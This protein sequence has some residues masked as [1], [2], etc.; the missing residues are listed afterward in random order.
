MIRI[1]KSGIHKKGFPPI[2]LF[3]LQY[4]INTSLHFPLYLFY[5]FQRIIF[6]SSIFY[7]VYFLI[8]RLCEM[9]LL[10][11]VQRSSCTPFSVTVNCIV[12]LDPWNSHRSSIRTFYF[13]HTPGLRASFPPC[14]CRVPRFEIDE[15]IT[16][17]ILNA[18]S[19]AP[20]DQMGVVWRKSWS[21]ENRVDDRRVHGCLLFTLIRRV[22]VL[23]VVAGMS[24]SFL[25][26][27]VVLASYFCRWVRLSA[28]RVVDLYFSR[29]VKCILFHKNLDIPFIPDVKDRFLKSN[30]INFFR[31]TLMKTM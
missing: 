20:N 28:K 6:Y 15:N 27:T 17:K 7:C 21:F 23:K 16:S 10:D 5:I 29:A 26:G 22:F 12:Y 30:N 2:L 8:P 1:N 19:T 3:N 25:R 14:R 13:N 31:P 11:E 24:F 18:T 4:F 9:L